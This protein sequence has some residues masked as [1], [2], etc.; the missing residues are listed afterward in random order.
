MN[1]RISKWIPM[2]S[3]IVAALLLF[4]GLRAAAQLRH[5]STGGVGA[6]HR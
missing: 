1:S 2:L 6:S 5:L 4:A 3:P